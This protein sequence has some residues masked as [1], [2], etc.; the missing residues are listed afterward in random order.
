MSRPAQSIDSHE[1]A[2]THMEISRCLFYRMN[3][4][5]EELPNLYFRNNRTSIHIYIHTLYTYPSINI[6]IYITLRI[7]IYIYIEV[8]LYIYTVYVHI[9]NPAHHRR[10]VKGVLGYSTR[11]QL[12]HMLNT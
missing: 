11:Y 12:S 5:L 1:S 9:P 4:L 2:N 10:R 8:L 7:H 3:C 6:Y